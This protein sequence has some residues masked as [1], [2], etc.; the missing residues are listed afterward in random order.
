MDGVTGVSVQWHVAMEHNLG[1]ESVLEI[2]KMKA[3]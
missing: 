3:L 2:A 1:D